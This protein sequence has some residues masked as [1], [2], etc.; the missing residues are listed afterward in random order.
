M[1][2]TAHSKFLSFG[3]RHNPLKA[4]L[5]LDKN[6]WASIESILISLTANNLQLDIE[7]LTELVESNSKK[8]FEF[9]NNGL[10]IRAC[11]GHSIDVDL[12]LKEEVPPV[13]L[14]H[15]TSD[16]SIASIQKNKDGGI[17]KM[18]RDHIHLSADESTAY[19]VGRRH[20]A[21]VIIMI[22]AKAMYADGY[23][24]FMSTNGVWLTEQTIIQKYFTKIIYKK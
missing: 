9:S 22:D 2:Y 1:D 7:G 4:G 16:K 19:M 20:G 5:E 23:K 11:Q 12:C 21:P 24:F 15:G 8:R 10:L 13:V 14:Y 3:L 6:G 17:K 18:N